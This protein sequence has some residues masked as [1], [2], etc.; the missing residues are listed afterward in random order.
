MQHHSSNEL[1]IEVAHSE[2]PASSLAHDSEGLGKQ[3]V[4]GLALLDAFFEFR[5]FGLQL[6]IAEGFH[7]GLK[8]IDP[9]DRWLQTLQLT[10]IFAA[11]QLT[12]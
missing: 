7:L 4:E 5:G 12:E 3:V 6:G 2:N 9:I 11:D 10:F 1:Y 8:G